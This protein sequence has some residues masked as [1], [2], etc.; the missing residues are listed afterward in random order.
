MGR[1]QWECWNGILRAGW[2]QARSSMPRLWWG[3]SRCDLFGRN[4]EFVLEIAT[5]LIAMS[6][7]ELR[8]TDASLVKGDVDGLWCFVGDAGNGKE[9][10]ET[11]PLNSGEQLLGRSTGLAH[12]ALLGR[13]TTQLEVRSSGI[14]LPL[15]KNC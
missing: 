14:Q 15:H 9:E 10:C 5:V 7:L 2:E 12:S 6:G 3:E 13:L 11:S 1:C 8:M 4:G